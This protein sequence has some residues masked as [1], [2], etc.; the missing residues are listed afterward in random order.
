MA[1]YYAFFNLAH[2]LL[3]DSYRNMSRKKPAQLDGRALKPP[4]TCEKLTYKMVFGCNIISAILYGL[5]IS[6]FFIEVY[7]EESKPGE[8]LTISKDVASFFVY[9][10]PLVE[11]KKMARSRW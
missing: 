2:Y 7:I 4:T 3:A 9:T 6:L 11:T 5:S 10:A 8:W 1:L